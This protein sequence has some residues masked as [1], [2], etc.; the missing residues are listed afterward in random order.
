MNTA[1]V[2]FWFSCYTILSMAFVVGLGRAVV[3]K[4]GREVNHCILLG[5]FFM[6]VAGATPYSVFPDLTARAR[7]FLGFIGVSAISLCIYA[8]PSLSLSLSAHPERVP[9]RILS[10]GA[11]PLYIAVCV[12]WF[13]PARVPLILFQYAYL[14]FCIVFVLVNGRRQDARYGK[15]GLDPFWR[16]M[17]RMAAVASAIYIPFFIFFD[18]LLPAFWPERSGLMFFPL[19]FIVWAVTAMIESVR[20]ARRFIEA[21]A[22]ASAQIPA[23]D[24]QLQP[25]GTLNEHRMDGFGLSRREK[26]V[27]RLLAQGLS[28]KEIADSLFVSEATIK[29]H[30][31]RAYMKTGC[32]SKVAII[33]A[34]RCG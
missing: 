9:L 16:Q 13:T 28:Y 33:N 1:A 17:T 8:V 22:Q 11:I 27:V 30:V 4:T 14:V 31:A 5:G 34:L 2:L 7:E 12:T 18:I 20:E 15:T 3:F 25:A 10:L 21:L 6:L 32:G 19:F 26:E 29:T 23:S 24:H